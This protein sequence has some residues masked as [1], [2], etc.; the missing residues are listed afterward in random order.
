MGGW[1]C[2]DGSVDIASPVSYPSALLALA[3]AAS[4]GPLEVRDGVWSSH[5]HF[6][7]QEGQVGERPDVRLLL[8][9]FLGLTRIFCL[10]L[11]GQNLITRCTSHKRGEQVWS[12]AARHDAMNKIKFFY[13][14]ISH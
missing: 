10:D 1:G 3:L 5:L 8:E 12:L 11:I 13:K 14:V 9:V 7:Q 6:N 4:P 2:Y